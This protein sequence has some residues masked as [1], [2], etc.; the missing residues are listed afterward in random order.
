L[1]S[2][3]VGRFP[4]FFSRTQ[5]SILNPREISGIKE[6]IKSR[7]MVLAGYEPSVGSASASGMSEEEETIDEDL[8]LSDDDEDTV[9]NSSIDRQEKAD[10]ALEDDFQEKA[11]LCFRLFV[12]FVLVSAM[13]VAGAST[14]FFITGDEYD[15]FTGV[16]SNK[17]KHKKEQVLF[18]SLALIIRSDPFLCLGR[19]SVA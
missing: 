16:V 5:T 10:D 17:K 7:S 14:W 19:R 12:I 6:S 3:L 9:F 4:S 18:N 11:V 2:L 15:D 13:A 1:T 8:P